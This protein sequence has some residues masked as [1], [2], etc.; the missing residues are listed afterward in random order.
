MVHI[1]NGILAIKRN[2]IPAFL[3]TWMDLEIIM[4][5]E[6]SHTMTPTSTAITDMWNLKKG[7]TELLCRTDADSQ[8]LKN[9][10]SPEETVWG[11]GVCLGCGMEIL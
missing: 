3:A 9:L 7:Q 1:H 4:L 6:V 8:T 10:W 5:S 2:E 11:W